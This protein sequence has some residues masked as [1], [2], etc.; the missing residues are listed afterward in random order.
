MAL[1]SDARAFAFT[2]LCTARVG[3]CVKSCAWVPIS[4]SLTSGLY[5][6]D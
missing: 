2:S 6:A 5:A 1:R 3:T 4:V